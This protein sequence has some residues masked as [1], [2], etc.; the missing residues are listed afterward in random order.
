MLL[1]KRKR[2]KSNKGY[3]KWPLM[4]VH[5]WGEH[6]RGKWRVII[7]DDVCSVVFFYVQH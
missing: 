7:V 3:T 1:S 5:T 6:P 4:S 2:D